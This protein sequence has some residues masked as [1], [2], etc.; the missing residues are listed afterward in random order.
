[1]NDAGTCIIAADQAAGGGYL[2]AP[3]NTQS[4]TVIRPIPQTINFTS[5]PPDPAVVGAS[6]SVSAS[7][8]CSGNPVLFSSLTPSVCFVLGNTVSLIARGT[9]RV[10]G[11]QTGNTYYLPAPQT[12]Q[13]FDINDV[14][15]ITFTS[16]APAPGF[17]GETY[18]VTAIGG[19][20]GSP[21]TFSSLSASVCTISGSIATLRSAGT[22]I[23]A[24]DQSEG[25]GYV[26]AH[27]QTQS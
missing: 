19:L 8:R 10:A 17:V 2:A 18:T 1:L 23:I 9:C 14:Q 15:A 4:F 26:A 25:G 27:R 20:S 16:T 24:A 13:T 5:A 12:V 11:D 6:Y 3:R 21:V 7:G 22:C